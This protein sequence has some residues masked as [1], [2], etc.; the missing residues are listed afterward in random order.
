MGAAEGEGM[1]AILCPYLACPLCHR[2]LSSFVRHGERVFVHDRNL[3]G[4]D[5]ENADRT[6]KAPIIELEEVK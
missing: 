6:F 4:P 5:C 3:V 2:A 1:K